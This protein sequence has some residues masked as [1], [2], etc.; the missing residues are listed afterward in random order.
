[1][2]MHEECKKAWEDY[3][4]QDNEGYQPDYAGFKCG[5]HSAW[6]AQQGEIERL[7]FII[8]LHQKTIDYLTEVVEIWKLSEKDKLD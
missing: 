3:P 8:N 4:S 6:R 2:R 1:M 7:R 5:F